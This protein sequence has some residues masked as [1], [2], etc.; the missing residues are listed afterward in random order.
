[1]RTFAQDKKVRVRA[2]GV[3]IFI[4]PRL[5]QFVTNW[6]PLGGR[7]CLLKLRLRERSLCIFQVYAPNAEAQYQPFLDEVGIV[8]Q[9]VTSLESIFLL[10]DFHTHVG[11][12]D[13]T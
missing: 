1:M 11:T 4:S 12:D 6:I 8:L 13:K 7:V 5:A 2:L 3:G 9:K 10:G